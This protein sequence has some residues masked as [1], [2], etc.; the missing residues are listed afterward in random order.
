MLYKV[1]FF[2]V[3]FVIVTALSFCLFCVW[4]CESGCMPA[5]WRWVVTDCPT[6]LTG[7]QIVSHCHVAKFLLF[8]PCY[9]VFPV[10]TVSV[11]SVPLVFVIALHCPHPASQLYLHRISSSLSTVHFPLHSVHSP[12][13]LPGTTSA[14]GSSL[15]SFLRAVRNIYFWKK[16]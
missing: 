3:S 7:C 14:C 15:V 6:H 8:F 5:L 12:S 4:V 1:C 10:L 9:Y 2:S 13:S 16:M 11:S